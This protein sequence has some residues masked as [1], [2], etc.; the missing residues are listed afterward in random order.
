MPYKFFEKLYWMSGIYEEANR[1][2]VSLLLNG[3]K[4]NYTVSWGAAAFDYY[5]VLFKKLKWIHLY[6]EIQSYHLYR[7]MGRKRIIE[8]VINKAIRKSS[9]INYSFPS[10]PL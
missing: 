4:G 3:A 7:G 6:N 1:S 10:G 9:N 8:S 2:K 5:A